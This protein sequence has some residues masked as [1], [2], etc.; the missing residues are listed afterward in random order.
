MK[1]TTTALSAFAAGAA[2]LLAGCGSDT[3]GTAASPAASQAPNTASSAA[4]STQDST[5]VESTG[6]DSS[7]TSASE[8]PT[9]E[10]PTS[11]DDTSSEPATDDSSTAD[12]SA[13]TTVGGGGDLDEASVTWFDTY[14]SGVSPA[15]TEVKNLSGTMGGA[16]SDPKKLL[17]TLSKTFTSMG[18]AFTKTAKDLDG[19][20]VPT[21][22][23][24][25]TLATSVTKA[26]NE[27]GPKFTKLGA[28]LAKAD[29]NDPK[30]LA[31]LQDLGKDMQGLQELSRF[32]VDAGTLA[33][34][35]EIPSCKTLFS[36][37]S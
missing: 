8:E 37:G 1:R 11:S 36:A 30:A 21:F 5:P 18:N 24:G 35:K 16:G 27:F 3:S 28:T 15:L 9:S 17:Q 23:G 12:T 31:Q 22:N 19:V 13:T 14:C 4:P 2:L 25:D 7:S 29:P 6:G 34:I 10:E 32:K 26:M 20:P 33:A